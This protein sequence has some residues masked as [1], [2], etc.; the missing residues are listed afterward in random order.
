M[1]EKVFPNFLALGMLPNLPAL[2]SEGNMAK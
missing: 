1:W 2:L